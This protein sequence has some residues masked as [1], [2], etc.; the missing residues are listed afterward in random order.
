MVLTLVLGLAYTAFG[1]DGPLVTDRGA[2]LYR[3]CRRSS[4]TR[5]RAVLYIVFAAACLFE[6]FPSDSPDSLTERVPFFWNINTIF[7]IYMNANVKAVPLNLL[8]LIL[9]L[10]GGFSLWRAVFTKSVSLRGGAADVPRPSVRGICRFRLDE[11]LGE[12]RDFK[13][14]ASRGSLHSSTSSPLLHGGQYRTG[15]PAG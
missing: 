15:Q 3:L 1:K 9:L 5:S 10:A 13:S 11:R 14:V 7:Q 6:L 12:R 2:T 8:E 4:G